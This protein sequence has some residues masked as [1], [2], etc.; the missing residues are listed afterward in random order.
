MQMLFAFGDCSH[1]VVT[2]DGSVRGMYYANGLRHV[3]MSS[4]AH[5][6]HDVRWYNRAEWAEDPWV[7]ESDHFAGNFYAM[8]Y[9]ENGCSVATHIRGK[10]EHGGANVYIRPGTGYW[11]A[12]S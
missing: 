9:G 11:N 5:F 7:S 2:T 6:P 10:N 3:K 1:Y 4:S 12:F 8:L